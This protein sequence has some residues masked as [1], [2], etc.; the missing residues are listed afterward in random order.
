MLR[1]G[2]Y[3]WWFGSF[4]YPGFFYFVP[5]TTNVNLRTVH[6]FHWVSNFRRH[7]RLLCLSSQT[8]VFAHP[9]FVHFMWFFFWKMSRWRARDNKAIKI[10][11]PYSISFVRGCD[12]DTHIR[13][14]RK[15]IPPPSSGFWKDLPL[16]FVSYY[17][18]YYF[19]FQKPP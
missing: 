14:I 1:E 13:P 7:Q 12:T 4:Y 8:H 18:Y 15:Y 19:N 5:S 9:P 17:Y 2:C 10:L 6:A 3:V 11:G 16:N